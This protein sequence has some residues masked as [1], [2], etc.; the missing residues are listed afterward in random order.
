M[1]YLIA[2]AA[3]TAVDAGENQLVTCGG[4][5]CSI[6]KLVEMITNIFSWL[7]WVSFAIAIL[8]TVVGG[9]IYIG[10]RGND[11][12][13]SQA[14]RTILWAISGFAIMLLAYMAI[15]TT[16]QIIGGKDKDVWSKF[17]CGSDKEA[18]SKD[19]SQKKVAE[20]AKSAKGSG[21]LSG[22]IPQGTNAEEFIQMV[23]DLS[24]NDMALVESAIE[25]NNKIIAAV[26]KDS[27]KQPELLYIDTPL[28]NNLFQNKSSLLLLKEANAAESNNPSAAQL[29]QLSQVIAKIIEKN[30]DLFFIITDRPKDV[31]AG[32]L[33]K[34]IDKI[35]QCIGSGGSWYRFTEI[36]RA[37][38]ESCSATKCTPAGSSNP[39]SGCKCPDGYC[40]SGKSCVVKS[41]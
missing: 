32:S 16:A 2:K 6:C 35:N 22:K 28:I 5:D 27:N 4:M 11:N 19:V 30:L 15:N 26:G 40:L 14:K 37:E 39:I 1:F 41:K 38:Q 7:L 34:A 18:K 25:Q 3:S 31:S 13:M 33:I 17:E 20:I 21:E 29:A 12:W 23:N 10:S 9:F 8:F 24:P 36:C